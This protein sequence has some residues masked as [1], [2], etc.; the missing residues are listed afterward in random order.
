MKAPEKDE[1]DKMDE[2]LKRSKSHEDLSN[3]DENEIH[4]NHR[5][6]NEIQFDFALS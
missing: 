4:D 1:Y 6:S 3:G 2:L 5:D